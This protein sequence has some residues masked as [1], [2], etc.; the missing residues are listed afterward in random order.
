MLHQSH[1]I[2]LTKLISD[3]LTLVYI[4][5]FSKKQ[6]KQHMGNESVTITTFFRIPRQLK[7]SGKLCDIRAIF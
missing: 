5:E 7:Q 2:A 1:N 3:Q 4:V 6:T